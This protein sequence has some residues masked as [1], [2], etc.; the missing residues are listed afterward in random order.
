MMA[1]KAEKQTVKQLFE[2]IVLRQGFRSINQFTHACGIESSNIY[3]NL[4]EKNKPNI[5]RL[6][7]YAD[8][9]GVPVLD[10]IEIWYPEELA[11]NYIAIERHA[12]QMEEK[13][14]EE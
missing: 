5:K 6:F 7:L 2:E 1:K 4:Q 9:L 3:V 12:K 13:K 14:E 10:L 11:E 8:T